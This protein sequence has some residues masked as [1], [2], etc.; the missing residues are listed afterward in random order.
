LG[1]DL[2]FVLSGFL[3]SNLLFSEYRKTQ[4]ISLRSFYLRRALKL[5]PGFYLLLFSTLVFCAIDGRHIAPRSALGEFFFVQ[6][7]L[8][9]LWGHTW[10][11]AVEEHFYLILPLL[12]IILAARSPAARPFARLPLVFVCVAVGC[13]AARILTWKFVPFEYSVHF[14]RSHLRFDSL[15]FGVLLGYYFNFRPEVIAKVTGK[16]RPV[17]FYGSFV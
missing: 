10:S 9:G 12:L 11:L 3:I 6:N 16:Y 1:V 8:G 4:S 15:F 13:L 5:Y 14:Q 17:L 7:Y 2:F